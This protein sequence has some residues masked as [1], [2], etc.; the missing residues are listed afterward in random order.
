VFLVRENL[1]DFFTHVDVVGK[2]LWIDAISIDQANSAERVHQV[3]IMDKIFS[4]AKS[5]FVWLGCGDDG[6][7]RALVHAASEHDTNESPDE[8]SD[9]D[10]DSLT[11]YHYPRRPQSFLDQAVQKNSHA[12]WKAYKSLCSLSYWTRVWILQESY[13][14]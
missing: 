6:I 2:L 12:F 14:G 10:S 8:M 3:H 7:A 9:S 4:R 1:F 13:F 11:D 5:V